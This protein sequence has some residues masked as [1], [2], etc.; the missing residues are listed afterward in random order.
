[1]TKKENLAQIIKFVLFSA[2]AGVIQTIFF[3][4]LNEF[5]RWNYMPCYLIALTLSVLWN[6]TLNV[7][8]A[9]VPS[10]VVRGTIIHR[11][12]R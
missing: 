12:C 5:T 7:A 2:S 3:T 8:L 4:I 11:L 6:L 10:T 1:M 9:A